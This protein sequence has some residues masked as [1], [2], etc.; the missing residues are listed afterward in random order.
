MI[1]SSAVFYSLACSLRLNGYEAGSALS[2]SKASSMDAMQ[3]SGP[4][5]S[6]TSVWPQS[7][8]RCRGG[9]SSPS[10]FGLPMATGRSTPSQVQSLNNSGSWSSVQED[11]AFNLSNSFA[12]PPSVPEPTSMALFGLTALGM[13]VM[14]RRRKHGKP[15]E[16]ASIA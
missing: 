2:T 8:S 15:V 14:R 4:I 9:L 13:G 6:A 11:V 7:Q 12:S 3:T 10:R 5:G 16:E 1:C